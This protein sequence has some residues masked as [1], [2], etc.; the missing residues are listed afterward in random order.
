[1]TVIL[2][3]PWARFRPIGPEG[4]PGTLTVHRVRAPFSADWRTTL[5]DLRHELDMLHA[6]DLV[7][8]VAVAEGQLRQDGQVYARATP[9]H[10]GVILA[11]TTPDQGTLRFA[12]DRF[13]GYD[14]NVR[15]IALALD[16]LRRIDRYGIAGDHQQYRGYQAIEAPGGDA[17]TVEAAA[18]F[19]AEHAT[20]AGVPVDA[21]D[22]L[23]GWLREA[24]H[25]AARRLHPDAGGDP[26]LWRRLDQAK[27]VLDQY[28]RAG[29][30]R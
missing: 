9:D 21:G 28:E 12:C 13:T 4:W 7:A 5:R 16:S 2:Q 8:Q 11:F 25:A 20:A 6:R 10:P 15:A 3:I 19:L 22:V 14:D 26:A 27:R 30:T 29:A 1:M 24:Y 18:R 23:G 17:T